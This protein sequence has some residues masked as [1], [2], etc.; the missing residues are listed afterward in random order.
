MKSKQI[1]NITA[2]SLPD[3]GASATCSMNYECSKESAVT[4]VAKASLFL[5]EYCE[6]MNLGV[7][8]RPFDPTTNKP[9]KL[10]M[11]AEAKPLIAA[12][13]DPGDL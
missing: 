2:K 6:R 12:K 10:S 1:I 7:A 4:A 8:F 9:L 3:G 5:N 13:E 11:T